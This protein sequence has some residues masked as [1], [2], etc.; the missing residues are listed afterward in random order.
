[1]AHD[2]SPRYSYS[3]NLKKIH[4]AVFE[5]PCTQDVCDFFYIKLENFECLKK[6]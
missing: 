2:E 1:M 4:L 3:L 6:E 5:I